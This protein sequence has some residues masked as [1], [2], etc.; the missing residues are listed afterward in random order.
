M[1]RLVPGP[2]TTNV[3]GPDAIRMISHAPPIAA[4]IQEP[5]QPPASPPAANQAIRSRAPRPAVPM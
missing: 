4:V 5:R 1:Q 2:A 3:A